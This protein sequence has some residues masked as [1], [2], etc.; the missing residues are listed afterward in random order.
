MITPLKKLYIDENL[1]QEIVDFAY[2][3]A[4]FFVINEY[5]AGRRYCNLN[6]IETPLLEK[7][8]R[9]A[10]QSYESLGIKHFEQEPFFGNFIGFGKENSFVHNHTDYS[11]DGKCHVRLNFLI[12]RPFSGGM[13]I[14]ENVVYDIAEGGCW[15]NMASYWNHGS[16]P[17]AGSRERIVLS[18]GALIEES[19]AINLL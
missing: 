11:P 10:K 18:L 17:V 3:Q 15:L 19:V 16:T 5:G 8:S 2:E 9:F 13:P 4:H 12:Q 6:K 1:K 7:V 14:I